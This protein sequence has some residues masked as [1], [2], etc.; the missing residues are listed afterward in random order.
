MSIDP[1]A[2]ALAKR[3]EP[4][5]L[6]HPDEKFFPIDPKFYLERSALW[7]SKPHLR[8]FYPGGSTAE[9]QDWGEQPSGFP[10]KPQLVKGEMAVLKDELTTGKRWLG[11]VDGLGT[12]PFLIVPE[13]TTERLLNEDRF[14]QLTGWE[15]F[16]DAPGEVTA[17]SNN[18]HPTLDANLYSAALQG[19]RS[20]YYAEY[21]TNEQLLTQFDHRAPNGPDL[22]WA[23]IN[24]PRLNAPRLLIYHF[25]YALHEEPLRGCEAAGEGLTFAT[26]AGEWSSV[27]ILI[28]SSDTP[29]FI[30]LTSRNVGDPTSIPEEDN[31][32][33][34]LVHSWSKVDLVGDHP[35]IFVSLGTHGNY[36]N[37]GPQDLVPFTPGDLDLSQGTC[38]QIE[39]LDDVISGGEEI[40][41]PGEGPA[42]SWGVVA[43]GL[44]VNLL[45]GMILA[46][47]D[48][49][50]A[51][52]FS[53]VTPAIDPNRK[54]Q[55]ETGGG[56]LGFGLILQPAGVFVREKSAALRI[57]D[58]STK[59]PAD[60]DN[61]RYDFIVDRDAQ[62]WWPPRG[63]SR[64]YA[65]RWGP[66]VTNDP[67]DRRS[68]MRCPP[69][70]LMALK[71]IARL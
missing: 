53:S 57:E 62:L 13:S 58:W 47:I 26:F 19:G 17:T 18:R 29:L 67:K 5:L 33:G 51:G 48:A 49:F 50:S 37:P 43:G 20:W 70:A 4:I 36:L 39:T 54:P 12:S 60:N 56:P 65:G 55:D 42:V 3:F 34:M 31:R 38:A 8:S 63:V 64:G 61:P 68:G 10:R 35:K 7:R 14:L 21:L 69:F 59:M 9:K 66:R 2:I 27:A 41:T 44:A 32:V 1:Q 46:L 40:T 22:V 45:L 23:V 6:F 11:E 24:N 15:P 52:S 71:G 25:F 16:V 28:D 30:G